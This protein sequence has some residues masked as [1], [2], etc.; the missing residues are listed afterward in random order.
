M[1]ASGVSFLPPPTQSR[2]PEARVRLAS[3]D[4]TCWGS[5]CLSAERG[6]GAGTLAD[7][8]VDRA[9]SPLFKCPFRPRATDCPFIRGFAPFKPT[10]SLD[11]SQNP[12]GSH[13]VSSAAAL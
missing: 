3:P 1:L 12:H 6:L 4:R 8:G 9:I 7:A 10:A 11:S 2:S 5:R 13:V